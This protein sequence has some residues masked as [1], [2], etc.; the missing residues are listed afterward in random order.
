MRRDPRGRDLDPLE[1]FMSDGDVQIRRLANDRRVALPI[2]HQRFGAD[3]RMLF[4]GDDGDDDASRFHAAFRDCF[5]GAEDGGAAAFHVLRAA[6][7][8][9]TVALDGR[10]RRA[11]SFDADGVAVAAQHE[12]RSALLR[13]NDAD[14]IGASQWGTGALAGARRRGR[15][16]PTEYRNEYGKCRDRERSCEN[17]RRSVKS[18]PP[19][20]C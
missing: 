4:I 5:R 1:S 17:S 7:V 10:E 20:P 18:H 11:H 14:H 12:R 8:H 9:A 6:A 19:P 2:F 13:F 16:R 15:R 3:A